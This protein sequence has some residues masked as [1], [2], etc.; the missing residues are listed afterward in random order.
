MS[1]IPQ[2]DA[3]ASH[4][5]SQW[6][7]R[8]LPLPQF[9]PSQEAK[10]RLAPEQLSF[11]DIH[12]YLLQ[13]SDPRWPELPWLHAV[14]RHQISWLVLATL[15]YENIQELYA[16]GGIL[17]D[18][19][20]EAYPALLRSIADP[21]NALSVMGSLQLLTYP[22]IAM[23]GSRKAS[24]WALG[25]SEKLA[26]ALASQGCVIV[27]GGALGCDMAAH[28]G[29]LASE[30][31]PAPTI[32]VF[33]GG[34]AQL[35]PKCHRPLFDLL[36][37]EGALL[38]SERLWQYP[39]RPVDFPARNRIISGLSR[40]TLVMQAAEKSGARLTAG[41]ALDQG[42]DV[43]V[44]AHPPHDVRAT[45]SRILIED[46]AQ[47][48]SSSEDCLEI[49]ALHDLEVTIVPRGSKNPGKSV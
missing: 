2:L 35:Y 6:L 21:P 24:P 48:F 19:Y 29:A 45:G 49:L 41:Y 40:R 36:Q 26:H 15:I 46:G 5:V 8:W 4:I 43:M 37:A 13:R 31:H 33:A 10:I 34:L 28:R 11:Q 47:A 20:H 32:I 27:S 1:W 42:R 39:A 3:L 18:F 38:V 7:Y 25:Q 14:E 12:D 23:V 17:L 9:F 22:S 44:L 16:R 30:L